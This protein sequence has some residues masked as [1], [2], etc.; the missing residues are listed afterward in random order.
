MAHPA[1]IEQ[2]D[3]EFAELIRLAVT[4]QI[5]VEVFDNRVF[6]MSDPKNPVE[7]PGNMPGRNDPCPC[8][9]GKKFKRCCGG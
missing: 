1:P 6:D 9:S 7:V 5:K 8:G 3:P 4:R 2:V